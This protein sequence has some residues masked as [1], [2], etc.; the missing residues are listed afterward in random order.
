MKRLCIYIY[1]LS[2][3]IIAKTQQLDTITL[4]SIQI[5]SSLKENTD[6]FEQPIVVDNYSRYYI[7]SHNVNDFKDF[8]TTTPSLFI[9]DYGSKI[10]ST[11]YMRG[12]GSRIDNSTVGLSIDGV[13]ILNKNCFDFSYF[14]ISSVDI[15]K[16]AQNPIFGMNTMMGVIRLKTISPLDFQGIKSSITVANANTYKGSIAYYHTVNKTLGYMFGADIK[17]TDGYFTNEYDNSHVDSAKEANLRFIIEN[18]KLNEIFRNSTY[19]NLLD[20]GGYPY[21][22]YD[23]INDK[24]CDV[25][26]NDKSAYKRFSLMNNTSFIR[27]HKIYKFQSISSI[28][29]NFDKLQLDNDFTKLPYFKLTQK[30][31][32]FA[33]SQEFIFKS[34]KMQS[35]YHWIIGSYTFYKY[36]KMN[37]PIT[38]LKSGLDSLILANANRGLATISDSWYLQFLQDNMVVNND[39]KYPRFGTNIYGQMD[40]S[41]KNFNFIFGLRF[42]Y[43]HITFDYNSNSYI[44]Y[45]LQGIQAEYHPLYTSLKGKSNRDYLEFLPKLTLK[46]NFDAG[47]LY[48]SVSRGSITGGY[49]TAMFGDL[50]KNLMMQ[51]ILKDLGL[52]PVPGTAL[53]D[54]YAHYNINDLLSYK[55]Q[56]IWDF[57]LGTKYKVAKN[58]YLDANIYYIYVN[59]QQITIFLTNTTTGRMMTNAA[60]SRSIGGEINFRTK[61][62]DFS[63]MASYGYTN[64]KFI[65]YNDSK[66][67]YKDKYLIYYPINTFNITGEYLIKT[68]SKYLNNINLCVSYNAQGDIYYNLQNTI[69]QNLYHILNADITANYNIYSLSFWA[70]NILN[71]SYN[72]FYFLSCGN[73]FVEKAKPIQFGVTFRINR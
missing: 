18:R 56:H 58:T 39:F 2:V 46:Y 36:L 43:E 14:D 20:Q 61:I 63:F 52:H 57:E 9:P 29:L 5:S 21:S 71:N 13:N 64:C 31:K 1:I 4:E 27:L 8:S 6:G 19:I 30:E 33:F 41:W 66:Q 49:N 37:A 10:T 42:D 38:F 23:T 54:V 53:E 16:G 67:D 22:L 70:R 68:D 51:N 47:I 59:N 24:V 7:N 32:D 69:K 45:I 55:P 65:S 11:I 60:H 12:L 40:Y 28:Q 48:S 34:N 25:N 73:N 17:T 15:L 62:N 35:K 50:I 72:T 3:A 44:D 26:Y